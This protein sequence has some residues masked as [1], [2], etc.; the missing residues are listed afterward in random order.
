[1]PEGA[2]SETAAKHA[3]CAQWQAERSRDPATLAADLHTTAFSLTKTSDS[4]VTVPTTDHLLKLLAG[5]PVGVSMEKTVMEAA[6]AFRFFHWYLRLGEVM[7]KRGFD[8]VLRNPSWEVSQL[9]EVEF[10]GALRPEI[11][12]QA[13]EKQ[14]KKPSLL[15]IAKTQAHGKTSQSRRAI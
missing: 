13:I 7:E 11:A 2:P 12:R 9:N 4:R 15:L 5:Q 14:K 8:C 10:F 1:M 3:A 6:A